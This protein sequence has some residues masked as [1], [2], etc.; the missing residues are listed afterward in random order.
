MDFTF[1]EE[2]QM[3]AGAFRDL[4]A[5]ICSPEALRALYD[6]QDTQAEARWQRL[7]E[8]GLFGVLAAESDGGMGLGDTDFVLLAEEAGRCALPEPLVEQAG[9]AVP[10]LREVT[11]VPEVAALLPQLA[12]GVARIAVVHPN[13]PYANVPPALTHWLACDAEAVYLLEAGAVEV[14]AE[15]SVD[16]GRRLQRPAAMVPGAAP[17]A[18]GEVARELTERLLNRGALFTAAQ[19]LGVAERMLH[20]SVEY[21]KQRH[22]FG[23]PIGSYQAIKHHLATVAVKL[24]FARAVVYAAVAHVGALGSRSL[25]AVSHAK[26]AAADAADLAARSAIQVHGAM[27]YSWEVDLHFYMKRAWALAGAW[28]DHSFHARCVQALVC[29]EA[30]P[31]GPDQTFE[32][33]A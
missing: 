13:N 12:S 8:M 29:G 10:A 5:D 18:G 25:A 7:A 16:A 33:T 21:A 6:G 14:V 23:K 3:M 28:G 1:T 31:L 32:R 17:L 20:I 9:V 26:L 30:F 27:G 15:P 2:Q 4:A 22:Q 24:E 11:A 19:S